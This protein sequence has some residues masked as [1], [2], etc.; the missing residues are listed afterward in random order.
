MVF[1]NAL[2]GGLSV[3]MGSLVGRALL[4]LGIGFAT[5]KGFD[6]T[7]AFLLTSIKGSIAGM[8]AEIVSFLAWLWV[9]KA[10]GMIF[11]SFTVAIS[12]KMVGASG[13]TKMV[14]KGPA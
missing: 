9:D 10:I 4:A 6:I 13:I 5:F 2:V 14:T 8:P 3:A 7:V 1:V 11:A 12:F